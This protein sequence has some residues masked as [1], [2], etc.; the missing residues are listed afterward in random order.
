MSMSMEFKGF[1]GKKKKKPVKAE[2]KIDEPFKCIIRGDKM[3]FLNTVK[4]EDKRKLI[5][6][7]DTKLINSLESESSQ[8]EADVKVSV[9]N[10]VKNVE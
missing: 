6:L 7:Q 8:N 2:E 5:F 10:P 1:T 3:P 9:D 4:V